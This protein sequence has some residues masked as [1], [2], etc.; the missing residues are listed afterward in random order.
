M[1]GF[2]FE[3]NLPHQQLGVD[4]VLQVLQYTQPLVSKNL[5]TRNQINPELTI[6][7]EVYA[8]A[9]K[10]VQQDL[11]VIGDKIFDK[12]S[13]VL[14]ISMETGTGK[15]YTY[16]KTI[17]ELNR[18]FNLFKFI[19]IV[20]TL[21]IKAGTVNF[22]KSDAL[23]E[24]FRDEYDGR[25]I[26]TY[27]VESKKNKKSKKSY[28][29]PAVSQFVNATN[30]NEKYIHVLIIN[31][32][33]IN[34]STI[35][36]ETFDTALIAEQ[37][38]VPIQALQAIKPI[39]ILDE[40]HRFPTAKKTWTNIENL[41]A[42]YIIRY[43]ATFND[44]YENL[45]YR[46]TAVDSF[47]QDLVK[48]I[49][50]YIETMEGGD[51]A[52]LKLVS[53]NDKK[54]AIFELNQNGK[55]K[56]HSLEKGESLAIAHSAISDLIIDNLNTTK[57]V[58]SNGVELKKGDSI[59]PY[60]YHETLED[61]MIQKAIKEHFKLEQKY[62]TQRPRIKPLTLFFID[63]IAGY[64]DG[65]NLAGSLKT[66]F[67]SLVI[68]EAKKYLEH[69]TD[70][71]YRQYLQQTIDDISLVHGGY[72]SKD[73]SEK[74]EKIEK[75][76]NDILHDKESLLSLDNPRRFIFSKWTLREGWDNPNVFQICKLRSSGS[77]TSKL[78][79]VGRGLRLPVNEHMARVKDG[80]FYLNYFVDFTEKDFVKTLTEEI[81]ATATAVEIP[82]TLTDALK[83]QI[84]AQYGITK[85][86]LANELYDEQIID[87]DDKFINN[88]Y[89]RLK[90]KYSNAFPDTLKPNKVEVKGEKSR[91]VTKMRVGEYDELRQLWEL[92][93][94]KAVLEYN[95][96]DEQQFYDLFM[97]YL[98][99]ES[100][101]DSFK[102]T[103]VLTQKVKLHIHN[104]KADFSMDYEEDTNF[105]KLSTMTYGNFLQQLSEKAFIKIATLHRA[106]V[107]IKSS[108]NR[109]DITD[110]LNNQTIRKLTS[111]FR[112]YLFHNA[113][114]K[115]EIKYK[116]V[117]NQ[118]HPS[119]F[120]DEQGKPLTEV[121]THD[122]GTQYEDT[123]PSD[124]YLFDDIFFDS[125]LEKQNIRENIESVTVF[126]K[127]PKNSIKIPVA[128]GYTYSPD[129]AYI[130]KTSEGEILNF[131]IETK[132]V[133]ATENLRNEEQQKI[134]YAEKFFNR[135][136]GTDGLSLNFVTQFQDKRIID[137][138]KKALDNSV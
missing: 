26:K 82:D 89:A 92:I 90:E 23:L 123:R 102:Y 117:S 40:P 9:I 77:N 25:E 99:R 79:E 78:Q 88:G 42:Q 51:D 119:K 1:A 47:N 120:T 43:G 53:I 76:I 19:I 115:L 132:D 70:E 126:S 111:G 20:P 49:T 93:N 41:K 98:S 87:D 138:I 27:I 60:S 44:N 45:L 29:P 52:S 110:Y 15:T 112:A 33:M 66:R 18:I 80:D 134:K 101:S 128:G 46:L 114:Q 4:A 11:N 14:D 96:K 55:K 106:F 31:S 54:H 6:N 113:L 5:T 35:Q 64:R 108:E 3:R 48:G 61:N 37:Y 105:S 38:N 65:N 22:L 130:I 24:H 86:V 32:G 17:Y 133:K 69:E 58:L 136:N 125:S 74:D 10:L 62:L 135:L 67:E 127:I 118:V 21:S 91:Q 85:R 73:N 8:N 83:E 50:A 12:E 121:S 59:N 81:N 28:M 129:F 116:S 30:N 95:I 13:R 72:F 107:T 7:S 57:V 39:V 104:D 103:G 75:E 34:S 68:A 97:E 36:N 124:K 16:T 94:Q 63:D 122:L 137:I 109:L 131:I 56:R 100:T 2:T 71:Y 84:A